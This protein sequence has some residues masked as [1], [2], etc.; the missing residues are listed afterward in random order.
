MFKAAFWQ[1]FF[2]IFVVGLTKLITFFGL[3]VI[4][5]FGPMEK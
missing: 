4:V 2:C 1:S 5:T 3:R